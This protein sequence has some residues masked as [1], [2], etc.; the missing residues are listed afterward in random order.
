MIFDI[1]VDMDQCVLRTSFVLQHNAWFD[2]GYNVR[3]ST[4]FS[5][6]SAMLGLTVDTYVA[7]VVALAVAWLLPVFAGY[8]DFAVFTSSSA[9]LWSLFAAGWDVG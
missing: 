6:S 7:L 2:S 3:L 4:E 8:D 1:M 5:Y 9:G